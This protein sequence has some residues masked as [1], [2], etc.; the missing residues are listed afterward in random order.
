MI[1]NFEWNIF[2][3]IVVPVNYSRVQVLLKKL[4][5]FP[6]SYN[7]ELNLLFVILLSIYAN[8][9]TVVCIDRQI[10]FVVGFERASMILINN[11]FCNCLFLKYVKFLLVYYF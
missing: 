10:F 1:S 11:I 8:W 3:F 5:N 2:V 4:F 9:I 6:Y 7:D